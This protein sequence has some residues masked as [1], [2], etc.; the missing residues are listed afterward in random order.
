MEF[1]TGGD[2]TKVVDA[3]KMKGGVEESEIWRALV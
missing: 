1:A 3:G 2:V